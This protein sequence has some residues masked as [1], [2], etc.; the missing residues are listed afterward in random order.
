[1]STPIIIEK[2][3]PEWPEFFIKEKEK[4]EDL[5]GKLVVKIEHIGSTSI[6]GMGGIPII[7]IMLGVLEQADAADCVLLLKKI[8]YSQDP[9]SDID[10]PERKTLNKD[11]KGI[12]IHLYIVDINSDYWVRHI[13]FRE[14]LRANPDAAREYN[15]LKLELIKKY[16][17]DREA[18]S[19][20]KAKF[21]KKVEDKAKKERLKYMY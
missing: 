17:Y 18:Y 8:G 11:I 3:N 6:P 13:L 20:G 9:K 15:L 5:L 4:I 14:F 7:D 19:Q 2:Y 21:I 1:M 10:F 12:K 16:R